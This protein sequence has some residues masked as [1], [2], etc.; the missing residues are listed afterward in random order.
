MA[1]IEVKYKVH[2][3][4]LY[5]IER[6]MRLYRELFPEYK[7]YEL[8]GGVAGFSVPDDVVREAHERGMFVLKRK[9]DVVETDTGAMRAFS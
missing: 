6:Q 3:N 1:I 8:Y 2:P 7:D 4:N 9:G 5:Q